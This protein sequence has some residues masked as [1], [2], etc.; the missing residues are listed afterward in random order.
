VAEDKDWMLRVTEI[1]GI[2]AGLESGRIEDAE[3]VVSKEAGG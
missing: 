1:G 2:V 3:G